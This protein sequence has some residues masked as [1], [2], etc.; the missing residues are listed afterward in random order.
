MPPSI[1]AQAERAGWPADNAAFSAAPKPIR[2]ASSWPGAGQ[3][4]TTAPHR[5]AQDER[6]L[7]RGT[8]PRKKR[9][10][11]AGRE[12]GVELVEIANAD[13]HQAA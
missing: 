5:G 10:G 11:G 12:A 7:I 13:A 3:L 1:R 8:L 4:N 9:N 2:Q 6:S